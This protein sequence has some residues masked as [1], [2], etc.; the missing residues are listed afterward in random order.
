MRA[1]IIVFFSIVTVAGCASSST[2]SFFIEGAELHASGYL[3]R[4]E[5]KPSAF[6]IDQKDRDIIFSGH[7]IKPGIGSVIGVR[8]FSS[9][10]LFSTDQSA[11]RKI[12]IY[13]TQSLPKEIN[14][15]I[16]IDSRDFIGFFS[17][18]SSAFPGANGCFGYA[19]NGSVQIKRINDTGILLTLDVVFDQQSPRGWTDDCSA[20]S[21]S[22]VFITHKKSITNL[23]P[24]DGVRGKHVY[25]E[26]MAP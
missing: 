21:I 20:V 8:E 6:S 25:D 22:S 5:F 16:K 26:T 15:T 18:S 9:K 13:T 4:A 3:D 14:S 19:K 10:G 17:H 7:R 12:S 2:D 11:F 24:W 23:T 1:I